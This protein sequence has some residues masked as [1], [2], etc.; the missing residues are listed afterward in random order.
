MTD[1]PKP[2]TLHFAPTPN[3]EKITIFLEEAHIPYKVRKM[4][5]SEGD[6]HKPAFRKISP[7]G[8]MP[9]LVDPDGPNGEKFTVFESGAILLYLGRKHGA[10]YPLTRAAQSRVEQWLFFQM[11]S[12]GPMSGQAYFYKNLA[13]TEPVTADHGKERY[14]TEVQRLYRVMDKHLSKQDYFGDEVSIADFAIYPWIFSRIPG[15]EVWEECKHLR[16][17]HERMGAR[18]GVKRGMAV[19]SPE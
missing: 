13:K 19:G 12:I 2:Y 1:K 4:D 9:A 7:N 3:G 14:T 11:A 10:F 18:P 5:L 17:W 6:Q 16:A 8:K 15:E